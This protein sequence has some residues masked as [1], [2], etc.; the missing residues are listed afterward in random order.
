MIGMNQIKKRL[1]N[2][3][4]IGTGIGLVMVIITLII[5]HNII[6]GYE[7]GTSE[8]FNKQYM[9]QVVTFNKDIIQGETIAE[10]MVK[11]A[12]VPKT[13]LPAGAYTESNSLIGQIAK[14][15][16]PRN[17]AITS[18]MIANKII[19]VDVRIQEI[20]AL[21]LPSDL[22]VNEYVDIRLMFPSGTEYIVLAQKQIKDIVNNTIKLDL[23]EEEILTLNGSIVDSYMTNGTKLYAVKYTDPETQ[24]K[25]DDKAMEIAKTNIQNKI[26][27]SLLSNKVISEAPMVKVENID[28]E[29][30]IN[31][32]TNLD[33]IDDTT[34]TAITDEVGTTDTETNEIKTTTT[35]I[36]KKYN[37]NTSTVNANLL[38]EL[39]T[40][41]AIEYRYYVESYNRIAANY[42][43]NGEIIRFMRT[44]PY[45][46]EAAKAKL[47]EDARTKIET[48]ITSFKNSTGEESYGKVIS[49]VTESVSTQK[50][51]RQSVVAGQ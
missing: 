28:V 26:I 17:V 44:N 12:S 22:E 46:L 39:L 5:T 27:E 15:N 37:F 7:K 32:D 19:G 23:S 47:S 20:N 43:P 38:L 33:V 49:G 35:S 41:Y 2:G 25:I 18:N 31:R 14:Y 13:T 10:N 9:T 24:I 21:V 40:K 16:I 45:V 11:K 48:S 6:K 51:L 8:K 34:D 3:I 29:E 42:Q 4:L 36:L 1:V 30:I 50:S